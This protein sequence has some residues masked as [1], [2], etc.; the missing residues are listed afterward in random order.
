MKNREP[1]KY[2]PKNKKHVE[3][4]DTYL[5]K[6]DGNVFKEVPLKK[7]RPVGRMS[8]ERKYKGETYGKYGA[9]VT[10]QTRIEEGRKKRGR[11]RPTKESSRI[12]KET[13]GVLDKGIQL[14]RHWFQYLKLA[15]EL[16]SLGKKE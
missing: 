13:G 7:S 1:F 8:Q 10:H 3:Q 14:H 11:G 2:D 5:V 9:L 4:K 16:E 12:S 6:I 15:L